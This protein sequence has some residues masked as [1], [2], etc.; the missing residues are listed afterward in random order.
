M[1]YYTGIYNARSHP[2]VV[3]KHR[4]EEQVLVEFMDSFRAGTS[5]RDNKSTSSGVITLD[6]FEHYYAN[7]RYYC[8][9]DY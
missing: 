5:R 3:S 8:W 2:D 6:E 7:L 4:T 1:L 9:M